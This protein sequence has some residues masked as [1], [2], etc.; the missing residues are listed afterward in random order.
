MRHRSYG[1]DSQFQTRWRGGGGVWGPVWLTSHRIVCKVLLQSDV[2]VLQS[3]TTTN[4]T[5]A[6]AAAKPMRWLNIIELS[7]GI[8][9]EHK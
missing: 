4:Q 2:K 7:V 1:K 9:Q 8:G 3:H 6:L 5:S